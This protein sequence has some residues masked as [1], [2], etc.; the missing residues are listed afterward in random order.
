[1]TPA[2]LALITEG[3]ADK[4]DVLGIARIAGI[5]GPRKPLT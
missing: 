3:R 1:M 5:M 2:T 4:G